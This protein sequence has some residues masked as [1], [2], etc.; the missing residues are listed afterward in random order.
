MIFSKK[1]NNFAEQSVTNGTR[2]AYDRA[3]KKMELHR[4][5]YQSPAVLR[6]VPV[7]MEG[8]ILTAS[9]H[10]KV[11]VETTGHQV[12]NYDWSNQSSFNHVWE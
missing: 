9:I 12:Q 11:E 4:D 2:F 8:S 5:S 7:G 6:K 1:K 10:E 3:V